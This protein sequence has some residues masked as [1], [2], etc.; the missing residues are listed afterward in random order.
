MLYS[1]R[2]HS[3]TKELHNDYSSTKIFFI[4]PESEVSVDSK[5]DGVEFLPD[6][7]L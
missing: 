1:F 2:E 5:L 7:I 4:V 3:F 6:T